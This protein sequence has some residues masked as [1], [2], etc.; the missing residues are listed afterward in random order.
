MAH[1]KEL[2]LESPDVDTLR[3]VVALGWHECLSCRGRGGK[4]VTWECRLAARSRRPLTCLGEVMTQNEALTML[5]KQSGKGGA[6]DTVDP[7]GEA[8]RENGLC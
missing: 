3:S 8:P 5:G 4:I 6:Q 7:K 2:A 1:I